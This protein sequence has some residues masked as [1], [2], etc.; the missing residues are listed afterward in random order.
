MEKRK[1]QDPERVFIRLDGICF[2]PLNIKDSLLASVRK[3]ML[4]ITNPFETNRN[5]RLAT[6]IGKSY[7][8]SVIFL[9]G[10]FVLKIIIAMVGRRGFDIS[11]RFVDRFLYA[12]T[13]RIGRV[14]INIRGRD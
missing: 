4:R 12:N 2:F 6:P 5:A 7:D 3:P 13:S 1:L 14:D 8:D 10:Y 11:V 9:V